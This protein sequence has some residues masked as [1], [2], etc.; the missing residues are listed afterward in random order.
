MT[1]NDST[2]PD[3]SFDRHGTPRDVAAADWPCKRTASYTRL[4]RGLA[5]SLVPYV[6]GDDSVLTRV[7]FL[8]T[9]VA[10]IETDL[11]A[12]DA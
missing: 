9:V 4:E 3:D 6:S 7:E 2:Y 5:A 1:M 10:R 12:G 8:R 11:L